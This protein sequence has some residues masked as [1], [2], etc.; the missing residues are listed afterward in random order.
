MKYD[1]AYQAGSHIIMVVVCLVAVIPL[2]LLLASSVTSETSIIRDGYAFLPKEFSFDAYR[3]ILGSGGTILRAYGITIFVTAVGTTA[4]IL[5]TNMLGYG[6]SINDLP[7]G[8]VMRFL[9]F[10]TMLFNGGLVPTYLMYTG[11]FQIKNTIIALILPSL[12]M[13]G[14]YV[15]IARSFYAGSIPKAVLES[16]RIDGAGEFRTYFR[17]VV[18]MSLPIIATIGLMIGLHYWNDWQNGLYYVTDPKLFSLQNLLNRMMSDIKFIQGDQGVG[19]SQLGM[20]TL[21]A[22]GI[23]MAISVIS[24]LPIMIVYPIFQKFFVKGIT[25]GAVKE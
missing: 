24:I 3:Y 17:I 19:I 7:G 6:L 5:I 16:A 12:L 25:L 22:S 1:R 20:E 14:F 4:G 18:P 15:M 8:R 13:N 11:V 23:K 10:F 9:V 2:L 21:P